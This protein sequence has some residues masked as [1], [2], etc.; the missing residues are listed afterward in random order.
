MDETQ[1]AKWQAALERK[2]KHDASMREIKDA[3]Y[4][5]KSVLRDPDV[6]AESHIDRQLR[7]N[8]SA[9]REPIREPISRP[10]DNAQ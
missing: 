5:N 9:N 3:V 8:D 1:R 2:R 7:E 4:R 10:G 6:L